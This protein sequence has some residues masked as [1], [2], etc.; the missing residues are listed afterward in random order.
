MP[1]LEMRHCET[2]VS[3]VVSDKRI[4]SIIRV[5]RIDRLGTTS[6][7]VV[8]L[9]SVVRFLV[10]AKVISLP[11]IVT[12]KLEVIISSETLVLTIA[13]WRHIPE[14]CILHSRINRLGSVTKTKM[15]FST[16]RF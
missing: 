14:D 5:T 12:V 3:T 13:T 7:Y 2:L 8:L 10:T 6:Y 9:G 1:S 4:A 15:Q 11:I 16:I